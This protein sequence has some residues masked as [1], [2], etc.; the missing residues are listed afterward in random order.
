MKSRIML[1]NLRWGLLSHALLFKDGSG[2]VAVDDLIERKLCTQAEAAI[3]MD[4]E[5]RSPG[6]SRAKIPWAWIAESFSRA[7]EEG[8]LHE[9]ETTLP[10]IH[11][12]CTAATGGIGAIGGTLGQKMPLPYVH[13]LTIMAKFNVGSTKIT[14][15]CL[16]RAISALIVLLF[17]LCDAHWMPSQHANLHFF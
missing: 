8:R 2:E 3:I 13:L 1:Q 12:K 10:L 16:L 7:D 4:L 17:G 11:Q 6:A 9:G 5:Q 15:T 14:C